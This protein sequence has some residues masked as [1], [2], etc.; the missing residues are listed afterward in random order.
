[1]CASH[2]TLGPKDRLASITLERFNV[3]V[4][5]VRAKGIPIEV[6]TRIVFVGI[7]CNSFVKMMR[8]EEAFALNERLQSSEFRVVHQIDEGHLRTYRIARDVIDG[9]ARTR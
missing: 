3:N 5:R 9:M 2:V 4:R 8:V 7:F 6:E 1:M